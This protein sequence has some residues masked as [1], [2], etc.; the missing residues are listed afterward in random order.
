MEGGLLRFDHQRR[1]AIPPSLRAFDKPH[2]LLRAH[3]QV[4]VLAQ[5]LHILVGEPVGVVVHQ[6]DLPTLE[7]YMVEGVEEG[8][9]RGGQLKELL[10]CVVRC[11]DVLGDVRKVV[12]RNDVVVFDLADF[13][14]DR[15]KVAQE[16]V[17]L[18]LVGRQN[19]L[20]TH[21]EMNELKSGK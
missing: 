20:L 12:Q 17:V 1:M 9:L 11:G 4:L 13:E 14:S 5:L 8:R 18:N 15:R 6:E 10:Q 7:N 3:R 16:L 19:E 2:V 21:L